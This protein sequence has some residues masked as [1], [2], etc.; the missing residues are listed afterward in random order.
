M[1]TSVLLL[2]LL[3]C[4]VGAKPISFEDR[5]AGSRLKVT[6]ES[7]GCFHNSTTYFEFR[8]DSVQVWELTGQFDQGKPAKKVNLGTVKLSKADL[9]GLEL[10]LDYYQAGPEGG[11]TTQD[12]IQLKLEKDGKVIATEKHV[13]GSCAASEVKGVLSLWELRTR[14]KEAI[15]I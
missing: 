3:P 7:Q 12:T 11:C 6:F 15:D 8:G 1:K 5:P 4:L 2:T 9:E 13:D 10:L 14:A